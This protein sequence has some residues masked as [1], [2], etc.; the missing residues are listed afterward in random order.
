M[1]GDLITDYAT[2]DRIDLHDIDAN[3]AV[4]GD[5]AFHV[6]GHIAPAAGQAQVTYDATA[7]VTHV[8][9]FVN[10]DGVSDATLLL[11]GNHLTGL[12]FVL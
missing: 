2:G 4:T 6:T 11:A 1:K 10:G 7:N 3:T 9:L 5:Q 12:V 8:D